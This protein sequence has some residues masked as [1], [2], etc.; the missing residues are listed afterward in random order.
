MRT[1]QK[2]RANWVNGAVQQNL[3]EGFSHQIR[4]FR[5]QRAELVGLTNR[6]RRDRP[7][8]DFKSVT[9]FFPAIAACLERVTNGCTGL[10]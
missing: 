9:K 10:Q 7:L 5:A 8:D 4:G 3:A 1:T 2:S 6:V